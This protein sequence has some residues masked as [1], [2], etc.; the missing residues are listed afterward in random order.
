[1]ASR[2][3]NWL[4]Q[5]LGRLSQ[6]ST[7]I[8]ELVLV[9]EEIVTNID[10]HSG[11]PEDGEIEISVQRTGHDIQLEFKDA[12]VAFNPLT[13][14]KSPPLGAGIESAEIGGLG[15]HLIIAMT[16][17]QHYRRHAQRNI[18]RVSRTLDEQ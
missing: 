6:D 3:G 16:S 18:L 15:V 12:G 14:V 10:R 9:G 11:L 5:E 13:D 7:V 17:Q 8:M 2:V 4:Q 1:M